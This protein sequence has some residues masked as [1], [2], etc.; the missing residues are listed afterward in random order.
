MESKMRQVS[1]SCPQSNRKPVLAPFSSQV[2]MCS[3]FVVI[4]CE[5]YLTFFSGHKHLPT[6]EELENILEL[7]KEKDVNPGHELLNGL[8]RNLMI[9]MLPKQTLKHNVQY[10]DG[11]V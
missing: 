10:A 3:C 2:H 1:I 5:A 7:L 4:Y 11:V 6:T 8:D 9:D